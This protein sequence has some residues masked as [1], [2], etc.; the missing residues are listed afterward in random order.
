[1]IRRK[2][3]TFSRGSYSFEEEGDVN[4]MELVANLSDVMLVFA[5]ALML[6]IV[7]HW[8]VDITQQLAQ[9]NAEDMTALDQTQSEEAIANSESDGYVD[10]GK[11]YRDPKTGEVYIIQEGS[12]QSAGSGNS[13]SA[14]ASSSASRSSANNASASNASTSNASAGNASSSNTAAGN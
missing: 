7:T 10:M 4:P 6:A 12:T 8:N 2:N 13:A 14:S 1:M 9:L 5:V 3:S 11:A